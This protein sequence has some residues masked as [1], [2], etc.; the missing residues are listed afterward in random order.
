[1]Q[2]QTGKNIMNTQITTGALFQ[3]QDGYWESQ[4]RREELLLTN[5]KS[6]TENI[7]WQPINVRK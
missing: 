1:M 4:L 3:G 2:S 6:I 7:Y 5:S